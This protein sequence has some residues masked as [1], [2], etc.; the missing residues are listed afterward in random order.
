MKVTLKPP[1][2]ERWKLTCDAPLSS[3]AF[4]FNLRHYN[5]GVE[6][7]GN[8]RIRWAGTTTGDYAVRVYVDQTLV[9]NKQGGKQVPLNI[10]ME[11]AECRFDKFTLEGPG[12]TEDATV[13][14]EVKI[15]ILQPRD[16]YGNARED[17]GRAVQVDPIKPTLNAPGYML[18]KLK[19]D[20]PL[21]KF[22]FTFNLRHYTS[23]SW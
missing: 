15:L 5:M 17:L 7:P 6:I 23:G 1:A 19:C 8:V 10:R 16:K 18:L 9:L 21:S 22:A 13:T 3:F 20:G 11:A 2:T 12:V 14:G 4:N